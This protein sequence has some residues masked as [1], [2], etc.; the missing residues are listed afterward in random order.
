MIA[1]FRCPSRKPKYQ[2]SVWG[3]R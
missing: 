3:I 1:T 2:Q